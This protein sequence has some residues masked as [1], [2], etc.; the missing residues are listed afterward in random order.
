MVKLVT[1]NPV[2]CLLIIA[3]IWALNYHFGLHLGYP[4]LY[5]WLNGILS[6]VY[7]GWGVVVLYCFALAIGIRLWQGLHV[8]AL[9]IAIAAV[10][11]VET[12]RIASYLFNSGGSCVWS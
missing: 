6:Q 3:A 10:I 4:F 9:E 8:K 2:K 11:F 7:L 1:S 12:P 5:C